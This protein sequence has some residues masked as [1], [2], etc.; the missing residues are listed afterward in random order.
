VRD[1]MAP[2]GIDGTAPRAA[3]TVELAPVGAPHPDTAQDAPPPR[4]E[5]APR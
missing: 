3:H 1:A 2:P 4:D 5:Q